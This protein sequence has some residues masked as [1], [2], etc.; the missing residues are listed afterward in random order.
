MLRISF[1]YVTFDFMLIE[2]YWIFLVDNRVRSHFL[3]FCSRLAFSRF[4][5]SVYNP[6][7]DPQIDPEMIPTPFLST[8][9]PK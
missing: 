4:P 9:T 1:I 6:R 7:N 3:G 2:L 8:S 5:Q